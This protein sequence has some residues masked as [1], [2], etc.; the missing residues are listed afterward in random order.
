MR[1]SGDSRRPQKPRNSWHC[2]IPWKGDLGGHSVKQSSEDEAKVAVEIPAFWRCQD[3]VTYI[4]AKESYR[5]ELELSQQNACVSCSLQSQNGK[6]TKACWGQMI[7]SK[8]LGVGHGTAGPHVWP[9]PFWFCIGP[10]FF[11]YSCAFPLRNRNVYSVTL[12][13]KHGDLRLF[14]RKKWTGDHHSSLSA[15]KAMW[16]DFGRY[17]TNSLTFLPL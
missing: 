10:I 5:H 1:G 15:M 3:H 16:P 12:H 17:V 2:W 14:Q 4:Y 8:A 13:H 11:H 7:V 9:A 6:V